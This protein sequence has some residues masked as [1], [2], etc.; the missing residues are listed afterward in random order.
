MVKVKEL[1]IPI[2][3]YVRVTEDQKLIN[4]FHAL[5]NY[6]DTKDKA[7]PCHRDVL[8]FS[9]ADEFLGKITMIDIFKAL[10][11]NYQQLEKTSYSHEV[12]TGEYVAKQFKDFGLWTNTLQEICSNGAALSVSEVMHKP[13]AGEYIDEDDSIEKA[14][15]LYIVGVHQPLIVRNNGKVTGVLRFGDLFN[16]MMKRMLVCQSGQN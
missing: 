12:L 9:D 6:H 4:V 3:E 5:K 11:P 8:V 2:Q 13:V 14:V 16:E 10:E 7:Q 1:M 15:H